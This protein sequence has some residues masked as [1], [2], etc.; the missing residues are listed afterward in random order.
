MADT[1]KLS[2]F[3]RE[4][5]HNTLTSQENQT[6]VKDGDAILNEKKITTSDKPMVQRSNEQHC[7]V[8][9]DYPIPGV[10]VT[11]TSANGSINSDDVHMEMP[12]SVTDGESS[13]STSNGELLNGRMSE[14][15]QENSLFL[16]SVADEVLGDSHPADVAQSNK[17]DDA[18]VPKKFDYEKSLSA[19]SDFPS[20][21]ET[22]L[23]SV[24]VEVDSVANQK[25]Q[26]E[27]KTDP[28]SQTVQEQLDEVEYLMN[29][30]AGYHF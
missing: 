6:P 21:S 15:H 26:Q 17:V 11:G 30:I 10:P 22:E 2:D 12:A 3:T 18:D 14:V 23:K 8:D 13:T 5:S 1:P 4:Q 7:N 20:S 16:H 25:T 28:S 19:S 9:D 29:I 24:D 27:H